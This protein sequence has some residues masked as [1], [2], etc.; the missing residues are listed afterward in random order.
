M[1]IGKKNVCFKASP[2]LISN[3]YANLTNSRTQQL[4]ISYISKIN[5]LK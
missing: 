4:Q 3:N 5:Q 1:T 2:S